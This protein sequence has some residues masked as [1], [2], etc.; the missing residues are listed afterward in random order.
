MNNKAA[1]ATRKLQ[2]LLDDCAIHDATQTACTCADFDGA[3]LHTRVLSERAGLY[4]ETTVEVLVPG[5]NR[6]MF[7]A[8]R[9]RYTASAAAIA[10]R[11]E[12]KAACAGAYGRFMFLE[13]AC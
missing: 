5:P 4:T 11:L 12:K 8:Q 2:A 3:C 9:A 1:E 6:Q 13:I 10:A 7:P